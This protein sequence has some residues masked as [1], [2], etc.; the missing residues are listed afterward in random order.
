MAVVAMV[1]GGVGGQGGLTAK[2]VSEAAA[3]VQS[4]SAMD[5]LLG[6]TIVCRLAS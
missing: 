6:W 5:L 3:V 4:R 2:A 1:N